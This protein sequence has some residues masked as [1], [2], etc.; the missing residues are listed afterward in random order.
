MAN[1]YG[2]VDDGDSLRFKFKLFSGKEIENHIYFLETFKDKLL[3]GTNKGIVIYD[4]TNR[5]NK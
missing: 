4:G 3:I 2:F 5:V 1:V